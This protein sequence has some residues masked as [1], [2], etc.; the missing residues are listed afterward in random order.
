YRQQ[1]DARFVREVPIP[2]PRGMITDRKGE[3]LA[4]SSP[5]ESIWANPQELLQHPDRLPQLAAALQV[6][7]DQLTRRLA[8]RSDKEFVYLQR[9]MNPAEAAKILALDIHGVSSQREFRRF[10]PQGEALAHV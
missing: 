3:P 5:V 2:T 10:Y 4:V 9:R 1:G 7:A 6:D 8:Q